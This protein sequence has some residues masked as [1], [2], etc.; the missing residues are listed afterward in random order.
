M[1]NPVEGDPN[2]SGEVKMANLVVITFLP[3][4]TNQELR[5]SPT[6]AFLKGAAS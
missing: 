1:E 6:Q 4:D 3:C 2:S 5:H